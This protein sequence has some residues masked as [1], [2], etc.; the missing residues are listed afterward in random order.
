MNCTYHI[1][2]PIILI[3]IAPH[4]CQCQRKLCVECLYDH[5]VDIQ[6]HTTPIKKF[7]DMALKKMKD[8]KLDDNQELTKQRVA[9]KALLTQTEQMMKKILDE[10]SQSIKQVYDQI[11]KVNQSFLNLI[12]E[13]TN[14]A[15]SSYTDIEKLVNIVEGTTV[16]DWSASK[17]S[18]MIEV[19]KTMNWWDQ[20]IKAF[21]EKS[22][23]E[24][25]WVQS[26][27]NE[28][29]DYQ[30]KDDLFEMLTFIQQIDDSL[31]EKILEILKREKVSDI[32][33]FLSKSN[34]QNFYQ[35]LINQQL[36]IKEVKKQITKISNVLKNIQDHK[37]NKDDYSS[38]IYEKVRQDLIK[39][40]Y[41]NKGIINFF[42]FLVLITSIDDKFIQCGSNG[43]SLL[44]GLKTDLRNQS[45]E[46]IRI[47]NTSLIGGNFARGNLSG[48]EFDNVNICGINLN[49]AQLLNCKWMNISIH[50]LYKLD[51]HDGP[52]SSVCF[53]PDRK[54]LASCSGSIYGGVDMSI[55]L[56]DVKTGQQKAKLDGHT[57]GI[58]LVCFSPDGNTLASG[59][60]DKSIRL[61][62]VK[63]GEQTALFDGHTSTVYSVCFSPDGN[64]LVSGSNDKSIRFWDVKTGQ[65]KAKLD[66][67]NGYVYSVCF[68]PDGNT[69]ASGSNDMSI[70]LWDVNTGYQKAK[71]D[72]HTSYVYSVCF[73]L[74][75]NTLASGSSDKS[76]RLWDVKTGQQKTKF[77]GHS[78]G[79]LSVCFSPDGNTLASGSSDKSIRLWDVKTGQQNTQLEGHTSYV[80]SVCFSPDGNTLASGSSDKSIRLWDVK[81]GQ[82]LE[83]HT[84][85]VYSVCFS[86]DGNTLALGSSDKSIR[87]W[88]IKTGQQKA[89]LDGHSNWVQSVC[90][91]PDGNTLA[92]CTS[93]D[94]IRLWDVKKGKE[95]SSA[96]KKY[97]DLI[98]Q[99]K[100]PLQQHSHI[101]EASNYITT[102]LISQSTIFQVQGALVLKGEFINSQGTD[103]RPLLKSK[104]SCILEEFKQ[105]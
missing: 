30:M 79:I 40:M 102:L 17:N 72:G 13:N 10:L 44:V 60:S 35:S 26:L 33:G 7:R 82:Q 48:S 105:K 22:K 69:L 66:G 15:G 27:I 18:Y 9:F 14:L 53:S 70:R 73:S 101:T 85:Y 68:S 97:K 28:E 47:K 6:K 49:G 96:K 99:F 91:S 31:Y 8:S 36:N 74:D 5:G 84:S 39:R 50:E 37:F 86:L 19:D 16:I 64:T 89:K 98:A 104:G 2:N 38:E 95:I 90:F 87:L 62:D 21:I 71:L 81:T 42:R 54:T 63:T 103:L 1:Q 11:E 29:E 100:I 61:W 78:N 4:K 43:L 25:Q 45:F 83:G 52:V 77:D 23:E 3:C 80:Y 57:N 58:L 94:S 76:I 24:I 32:L 92:S 59:S 55:R 41:D 65:Q 67:H 56:W 93:D 34:H 20:Q 88:D 46:N 75:G 12:N 51:G